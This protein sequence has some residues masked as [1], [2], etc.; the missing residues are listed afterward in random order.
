MVRASLSSLVLT[1]LLL[2]STALGSVVP[3]APESFD[4]VIVGGGYTEHRYVT[5]F[6]SSRRPT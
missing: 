1:A 2:P 6:I 3:R 4:Y 5:N